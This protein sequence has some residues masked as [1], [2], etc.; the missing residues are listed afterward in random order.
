MLI[1]QA[2]IQAAE[3]SVPSKENKGMKYKT[4][5]SEDWLKA[6]MAAKTIF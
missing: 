4:V 3:R 6:E 1:P 5:K 2:Y